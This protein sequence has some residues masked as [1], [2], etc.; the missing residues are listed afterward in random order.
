MLRM[1][2][3]GMTQRD[4]ANYFGVTD[5]YV[6]SIVGSE[7]GKAFINS[8]FHVKDAET[9]QILKDASLSAALLLRDIVEDES[10]VAKVGDRINAAKTVLASS[11]FG[12]VTK[13]TGNL[14]VGHL[15][16][17]DIVEIKQR[18]AEAAKLRGAAVQQIVAEQA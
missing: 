14:L 3:S 12:P 4:I 16:A 10:G 13:V 6:S 17:E 11:G 18:A 1:A 15:T 5:N 7:L 8:T 2:A 9:T